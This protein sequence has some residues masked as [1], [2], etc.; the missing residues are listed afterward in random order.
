MIRV[1]DHLMRA[2]MAPDIERPHAVL[3]H[4]A[5]GH[6]LDLFLLLSFSSPH[7]VGFAGKVSTERAI[8]EIKI[9]AAICPAREVER[10]L[11]VV[12]GSAQQTSS[13]AL[14]SGRSRVYKVSLGFFSEIALGFIQCEGCDGNV[15]Q[16]P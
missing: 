7:D 11:C 4:V 1:D 8:D 13:L 6:R 16:A 3:A 15:L 9:M 10:V 14:R 5:E 2:L 12:V